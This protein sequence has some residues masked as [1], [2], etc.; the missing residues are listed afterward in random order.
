LRARG[1][2]VR[3]DEVHVDGVRVTHPDKLL[4]PADGI[5]KLDLVRY[6]ARVGPTMLPYLRDRPLTL[7]PFPDGIDAPSYYLK[8]APRALPAWV[9]TW[10]DV[11]ESTGKPVRFVLGGD[12]PTLLWCAQYNAI[13]VHP[14]LA[15][16]DRSDFP[17]RAVVDL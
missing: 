12:L 9:P 13:E 15:R 2:G 1:A 7:R 10:S 16:V 5:T 8:N 4:W 17:A 6:Y 3:A 11:A 14:W